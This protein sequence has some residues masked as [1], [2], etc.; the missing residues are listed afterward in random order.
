MKP[1]G[2]ERMRRGVVVKGDDVGGI[3]VGMSD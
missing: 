2:G 3:L 1:W